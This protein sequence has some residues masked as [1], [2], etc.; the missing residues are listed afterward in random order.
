MLFKQIVE[1]FIFA[2]GALWGNKLR[3]SLS[4][5]GIVIGIFLI[6]F[7]LS[8]VDSLK[9]SVEDSISALGSDVIFISKWPWEDMGPDY[10]WWKYL[11]RP[12]PTAED[13]ENIK[14]RS[15]AIQDI[16]F[17]S[18]IQTI[19]K[20]KK[21]Y[22]NNAE[23]FGISKEFKDVWNF[24]IGEGRYFSEG[25]SRTGFPAA[26]LGAEIAEDLYPGENA[27]GKEIS[28]KGKKMTIIG[29]LKK[30]G[31]G[32]F[33][34]FNDNAV[35]VPLQFYKSV[36]NMKN[37]DLFTEILV[38]AKPGYSIEALK[39]ELTGIM[40]GGRRLKPV[41]DNNFS[42]NEI[43]IIS[44]Q[45]KSIFLVLNLVGWLIGMY[46]ILIGGFGVAQIMFVSVKERTAMIGIQKALGAKRHFILIQ[47]LTE[48]VVLSLFG[49]FFGLVLVLV[50]TGGISAVTD[51]QMGLSFQNALIGVTISVLTG[52]FSGIIPAYSASRLDPVEAMRSK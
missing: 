34:G 51:F 13:F 4:L 26:I 23:I 19:V 3:S 25:E 6:I 7:V 35:F 41:E 9:R 21:E 11:S 39:D 36:V 29:I 45:T 1:S 32:L 2:L 8:A 15:S 52:L 10:P 48:A 5:L 44:N 33:G 31:K 22:V 17:R 46:S 42:L 24:P 30:E 37:R 18:Q 49:C 16:A 14:A 43:T 40:R 28:F 50:V 12:N 20:A 47:F 27:I 38:K